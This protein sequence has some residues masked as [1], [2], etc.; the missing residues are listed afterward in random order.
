MNQ[1]K[2]K[3]AFI[4]WDGLTAGGTEKWLHTVAVS[5]DKSKFEIDY[6]YCGEEDLNKK[7]LLL[8]NGI[9]LIKFNLSGRI[10]PYGK[11]LDT[12]FWQKFDEGK[13][14]LIHAAKAGP[15]E[16]PFYLFSKPVVEFV[17]LDAGVDHS[18]NI[19]YS[20][21][22]SA[23]QRNKWIE[24]GG[25]EKRSGIVPVGINL[26]TTDKDLREELNISK[27][28]IVAGYHQ[29]VDDRTYSDIPLNSFK[30]IE[31]DNYYFVLLGG[32]DKY[33]EQ[34]R[35][36]GI[37]NIIF[38]D[39]NS[40][41]NYISMFLNTLDIFAHGRRDG[42]TFG[43]VF[44]EALIHSK[45]CLSHKS[46]FSN[47]HRETMASH[48]LWAENQEEYTQKLKELFEN[49]EL[50]EKLAEG[51]KEFAIKNYM[52]DNFISIVEDIYNKASEDYQKNSR[53]YKAWACFEKAYIIFFQAMKAVNKIPLL[54]ILTKKI[55]RII[56]GQ[57][58]NPK[59]LLH[60]TSFE[61]KNIKDF[62][63]QM[64][65][66]DFEKAHEDLVSG[67]DKNSVEEI[68]QILKRIDAIYNTPNKYIDVYTKKERKEIT[69]LQE[70]FFKKI[71]KI[72]DNCYQY[73]SYYMPVCH[74]E[75]GIFYYELEMKKLKRLKEI[76]NRDI[77]D[78]GAYIGDSA[79]VLSKYTNKRV[80]AFEPDSKNYAYMLESIK[81]N[82][83]EKIIPQKLALGA[84]EQEAEI[85]VSKS[86]SSLVFNNPANQNAEKEIVKVT[87]LDKFI[88]K[89]KLDIGLIK[90]DIEGFEQEFLLGAKK[91]IEKHKPTLMVSIYHNAKDFFFIKPLIEGWDLGYKFRVIRPIDGMCILAETVL[92]A[93]V[94]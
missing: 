68:N 23:W 88:E 69:K 57:S 12:D 52:I 53:K 32:S 6:Y 40:D 43:T 27:F 28:A 54:N 51:A 11:W 15:K 33:R 25:K 94:V 45:P 61:R 60:D 30:Q 39:H 81:L 72:N 16:Y 26:P 8:E 14:D 66:F 84:K 89:N 78:V 10:E 9:K 56:R 79:V 1:D 91:T 4:K 70:K 71:K 63:L 13:Y 47:A 3:I 86:G 75:I 48:G 22:P 85:F 46:D 38:I 36:L 67:L 50:R 55:M 87:S 62:V 34:A 74:F 18:K 76:K 59:K 77:V 93:E 65:E 24:M 42:E 83:T 44:A 2:I 20:F 82:K 64:R 41:K 35:E 31:K 29:R 73:G 5:L 21:H 92:I 17:A 49:K 19:F 80:W 37:K 58:F 7:Q 90:V